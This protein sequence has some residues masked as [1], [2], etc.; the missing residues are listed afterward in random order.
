MNW[1]IKEYNHCRL[2]GSNEVKTVLDF[3][4]TALANSYLNE[5]DLNKEEFKAP[6]KMFLCKCGS[7]QLHHT[8]N[9]DLLF[10]NYLYESSTSETFK[11]HFESYAGHVSKKLGLGKNDIILEIGSNDNILL[12][13]FKNLGFKSIY[14]IDPAKN[15]IEKYQEK[16]INLICD[17]F[18]EGLSNSEKLASIKGKVSL[19]AANNVFAHSDNLIDITKGIKNLLSENG[20]FVFEVTY[21]YKNLVNNYFD[22]QYSEH[23]FTHSVKPLKLFFE[24]M[25]MC[26]FDVEEVPTHGGSIRCFVKKN[27]SIKNEVS[28]KVEEMINQE[29]S[30]GLYE[31]STYRHWAY[32]IDELK[33]SL[34]QKL[35]EIK[36]KKEKI[37]AYGCPAKLVTF[38]KVMGIDSFFIEKVVDDSKVKQNKYT[39]GTRLKIVSKENLISESP[40]NCLISAWNFADSIIKN[41]PK[42][43]GKWIKPFESV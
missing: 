13:P 29:E 24:S 2:C 37:W 28:A 5:E 19:I 36:N 6:L 17:Y 38:F 22:M 27:S 35:V 32:R 39:P 23:I 21:L 1:T 10:K 3:G 34:L 26:L 11:K 9:P 4:E 14:G 31:Y 20:V 30:A 8:V 16:G 43:K 42:Y 40:E 12:K 18:T 33:K 41:N 15:L 7:F 25:G